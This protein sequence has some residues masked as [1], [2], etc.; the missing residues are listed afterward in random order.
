MLHSGHTWHHLSFDTGMDE[1]IAEATPFIPAFY[2]SKDD[3]DMFDVR[4]AIW[5]SKISS[6]KISVAPKLKTIPPTTERFTEH[7]YRAHCM[8][9][10]PPQMNRVHYDLDSGK[11]KTETSNTA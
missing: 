1:I 6:R 8:S 5:I 4:Y 11:W 7:V 2:V 9:A 3:G 10:D